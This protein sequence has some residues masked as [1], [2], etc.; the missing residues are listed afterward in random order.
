MTLVS[1]RISFRNVKVLTASVHVECKISLIPPDHP[2][3]YLPRIIT[4]MEGLR[5]RRPVFLAV[6]AL[7]SVLLAFAYIGSNTSVISLIVDENAYFRTRI[8]PAS[9]ANTVRYNITIS[10][11][12]DGMDNYYARE[13]VRTR[14]KQDIHASC[15]LLHAALDDQRSR[16]SQVSRGVLV[17]LPPDSDRF[18]RELKS[19]YLSVAVMRSTQALSIKTDLLVFTHRTGVDFAVSLGCTKAERRS[20]DDPEACIVYEHIPLAGRPNSTDPLVDYAHY[21]DSMLV[22]AEFHEQ[23]AYTYLLRSDLD[24]FLTPGFSNWTL[25]SNKV[26]ATGK[27]GYGSVSANHHLSWLIKD[28]LGLVDRSTLNV[29]S[30]WYGDA[31][32]MVA[33]ANLT[34]ATMRWLDTQEFTEYEKHHSGTDGWPNWHWPVIL[35]YAGHVG[36][37]QIPTEM[38][39]LHTPDVMELDSKADE[40]SPLRSATRHIHC[41][42]TDSFFSKFRF[43]KGEYDD[44]DLTEFAS[45][46]TGREYAGLIAISS[47]RVTSAELRGLVAGPAADVREGKWKRLLPVQTP[48]PSLGTNVHG[49][50]SETANIHTCA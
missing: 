47:D 24:T 29:G 12:D 18:N 16:P 38:L 1:Y 8:L 43:Q 21:V 20:F 41:W 5:E 13:S 35:L 23:S 31:K 49:Y 36:V 33:V 10:E 6:I 19:H 44:M 42:Q 7:V 25:E 27:G 30:T 17:F 39:Q 40:T 4:Q 37:N 14:L 3:I 26:M 50:S 22:L 45:M 28:K 15:R 32:V 34:I 48:T 2:R 46:R 11:L 9:A